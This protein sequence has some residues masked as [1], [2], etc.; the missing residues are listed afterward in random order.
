MTAQA[1]RFAKLL[2]SALLAG[3]C[4]GGACFLTGEGKV[5]A[6]VVVVTAIVAAAKDLQAYW[7]TSPKHEAVIDDK[8]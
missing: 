3:I 6:K 1:Q 4:A 2:F 8:P 7:A 5:A